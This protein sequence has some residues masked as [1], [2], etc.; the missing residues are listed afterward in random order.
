MNSIADATA[1][2]NSIGMQHRMLVVSQQTRTSTRTRKSNSN[3]SNTLPEGC[4]NEIVYTSRQG[5]SYNN[6]LHKQVCVLKMYERAP[7]ALTQP[8]GSTASGVGP[9]TYNPRERNFRAG[10]VGSSH[11]Q[12]VYGY[13]AWIPN[14]QCRCASSNLSENIIQERG[15]LE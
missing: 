6:C 2:W 1:L 3:I 7:R 9:G 4:F 15:S 11:L 12:F 13:M 10:S 14:V 8:S 5:H